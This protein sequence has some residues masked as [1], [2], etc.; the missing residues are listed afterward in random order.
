MLRHESAVCCCCPGPSPSVLAVVKAD[1]AAEPGS[2]SSVSGSTIQ[3][4]L[5]NA[6]PH[7]QQQH[8]YSLPFNRLQWAAALA[9]H[10]S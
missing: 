9:P 1:L 10:V 8:P 4:S 7:M 6:C 3:V 5:P 2:E